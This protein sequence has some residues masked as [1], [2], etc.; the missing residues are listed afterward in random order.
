MRVRWLTS[1]LVA[2]SVF[3]LGCDG[4]SKVVSVSGVATRQGAPVPA[5]E[6]NFQPEVGR[7][8][9]GITDAQGRF[10]L[11]YDAQ[12]KGAERGKHTVSVRVLP[13]S[14]EEEM[15]TVKADP[16]RKEIQAKYGDMAKSPMKIEIAEATSKLE[17][18]FD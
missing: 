16:K 11:E 9:W 12:N 15:G 7:P 10:T 13:A 17:L 8:S 5:L 4:G 6:L 2:G 14:P 3:A 18:K 1:L